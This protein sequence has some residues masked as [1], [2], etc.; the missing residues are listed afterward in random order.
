VEMKRLDEVS[1]VT[2][3]YGASAIALMRTRRQ[4]YL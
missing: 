2:P 3:T 1:A 4:Q